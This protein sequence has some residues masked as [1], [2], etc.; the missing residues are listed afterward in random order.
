MVG[1]RCECGEETTWEYPDE[2]A[3]DYAV[4]SSSW[5]ELREL[6]IL[7][8]GRRVWACYGCGEWGAIVWP[9]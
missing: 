8:P 6:A 7:A 5:A 9:V 4:R 3:L 2:L 1:P